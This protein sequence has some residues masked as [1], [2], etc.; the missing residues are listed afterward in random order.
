M[1]FRLAMNPKGCLLDLR[2]RLQ[3]ELS[4]LTSRLFLM[5][6]KGP[7]LFPRKFLFVCVCLIFTD[8]GLWASHTEIFVLR[9]Q[10][11]EKRWLGTQDKLS[12]G[13]NLALLILAVVVLLIM[14][15]PTERLQ[16]RG[17]W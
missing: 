8:V 15:L 10:T 4:R 9:G 11:Q 17:F 13:G 5:P 12:V 1:D 16:D 2:D 14:F 7:C 6:I 3:R